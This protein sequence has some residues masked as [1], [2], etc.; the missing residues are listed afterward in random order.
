MPTTK[1]VIL[2]RGIGTRMQAPA[3]LP[4]G[5]AQATAA[6]AGL[7]GMI[8]IGR[9]FLD[10]A[11]SALADAGVVDV[12]IVVGPAPNAIRAHYETTTTERVQ[13]HFVEQREPRGAADAL[14][15]A[16]EFAGSDHVL[17]VNSD[18]YYPPR[19]L[20]ALRML[21]SAGVAAFHRDAL[22]RLSNIDAGRIAEYAVI[23]R[24]EDNTLRR[25]IEKPGATEHP[26]ISMNSW[27]MP[28]SIYTA[29]RSIQPSPRGELELQSAVQ[30]AIDEMGEKF[31]VLTFEDGVLDLSVRTDIP[32]VAERL[33]NISPR[34]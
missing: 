19:S 8:P 26:Y 33:R 32:V 34:L 25:I 14:A 13:I 22:V 9:P 16:E 1:A 11:I 10:Y 31:D 6:D 21:D 7:K 2:A 4:L 5:A 3:A 27:M 15:V 20:R 12:C 17:V 29:C 28:P 18:N 23:E 24:N 30:Y